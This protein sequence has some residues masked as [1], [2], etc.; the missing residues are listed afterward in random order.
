[1]ETSV[2]AR[3]MGWGYWDVWEYH[4]DFMG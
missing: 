3:G 4:G 1:M 2:E